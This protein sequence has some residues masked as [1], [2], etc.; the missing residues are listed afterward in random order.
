MATRK[1]MIDLA[2]NGIVS[3][4]FLG[5]HVCKRELLRILKAIR[6]EY[7]RK[8]RVYRSNLIARASQRRRVE[9]TKQIEA[10]KQG[11]NSDDEN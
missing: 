2:E 3:V 7:R 9:E 10:E 1:I 5:G 6:L 8:V 4:K 11:V